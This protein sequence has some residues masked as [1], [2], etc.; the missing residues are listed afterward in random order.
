MS[1]MFN[2]PSFVSCALFFLL[3]ETDSTQAGILAEMFLSDGVA[4]RNL[5]A[6]DAL[7]AGANVA[8][9]FSTCTQVVDFDDGEAGGRDR[10]SVD[11]SWP[12]GFLENFAVRFTA[13]IRITEAGEYTFGTNS[14][15]A[16]RLIINTTTV[17]LDNQVHAPEDRFGTITLEA[18]DH[19]LELV[20]FENRGGAGIELFAAPGS[21]D[22]FNGDFKLVG[23][24]ANG[25]LGFG[26]PAACQLPSPSEM[27]RSSLIALYNSTGGQGWARNNGWQDGLL[28][29]D[30]FNV[31]PCNPRGWFGVNCEQG[32]VSALILPGNNLIGPLPPELGD[33]A[34][35]QVL[36]LSDNQLT[37]SIPSQLGDLAN[38]QLLL[39]VGNQLE[40]EVPAQ[41]AT[42]PEGV[43]DIRGNQL[44][45]VASGLDT[46][47]NLAQRGDALWNSLQKVSAVYPQLAVGGGFEVVLMVSSQ[48]GL[49]WNGR[50]Y[51]DGGVWPAE[52][53]WQ[54]DGVEMTGES[55][56][57]ITLEPRGTKR[58]V[59][60][61]SSGAAVDGWLSLRAEGDSRPQDAAAAYFYNLFGDS[62]L[63][64]SAGVSPSALATDFFF[65][66]ERSTTLATVL[67]GVAIRSVVDSVTLRVRDEQGN[68]VADEEA[69]VIEDGA[70]CVSKLFP[71]LPPD[72][73]GSV[74]VSSG[75]P[76][77]V[78]VVR[79]EVT[80]AS[81]V[82]LTS[83]PATPT[84]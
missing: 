16:S 9:Q 66:V 34:S 65:P 69:T 37:G 84:P 13:A 44:E 64:D 68:P 25:G 15:D 71:G 75:L 5:A 50:V 3:L 74:R 28:R 38:V 77:Y 10:F 54:L 46:E 18:G 12:D 60:S 49:P 76:F 40:G 67:T 63:S 11:F 48:S 62:G 59:L 27:D 55:S 7:I 56:F 33:L 53:S 81:G 57:E 31:D 17:I 20:Y 52:R 24:T 21:F 51:L 80:D 36:S 4:V 47:L 78:T 8:D 43:L 14:D 83:V 6:A 39:L 42:L 29:K 30:G 26:E 23:D 58:M 45:S 73:V 72:F 41:I 1:I 32:R 82:Q 19:A 61:S 79:V 35:L 70:A 2:R 22:R